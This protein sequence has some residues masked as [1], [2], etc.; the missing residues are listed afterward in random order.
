MLRTAGG[1]R[2]RPRRDG[3]QR[4]EFQETLRQ[5][6]RL[7]QTRETGFSGSKSSSTSYSSTSGEQT[8]VSSY[9]GHCVSRGSAGTRAEEK[10]RRER[11]IGSL[12]PRG[13]KRET[14]Q[15]PRL[16]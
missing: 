11:R 5:T 4:I 2:K 16:P 14:A 12:L 9:H 15:V 3:T 8:S 13:S 6:G 7:K 1:E 10:E